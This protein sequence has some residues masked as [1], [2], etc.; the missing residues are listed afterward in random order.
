MPNEGLEC[1]Q[2]Y[3][4]YRCPEFYAGVTLKVDPYMESSEKRKIPNQIVA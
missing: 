2:Q 3:W 1:A 4:F